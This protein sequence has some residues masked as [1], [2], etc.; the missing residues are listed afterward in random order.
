MVLVS[1]QEGFDVSQHWQE[2][3]GGFEL[4][5]IETIVTRD[6]QREKLASQGI[7]GDIYGGFVDP[8]FYIGLGIQVGIDSGI[9]AEG[10]VNMLSSIIQHRPVRLGETLMSAGR[11]ESVVDVPRGRRITTDVWFEDEKGRRAISV[12][13][14]SLKPDPRKDSRR[15]AGERPAPVIEDVSQLDMVSTH[16]MSPEGTKSYS[17]EGNAI[18]YEMEAANRAGFRA[19]I[20]GGGQGV[21]YLMAV[22]WG[23]GIASVDLE[24]YFR[25]PI[26][27]DDLIEV[28]IMPD[29]SALASVREGKVLTEVRVNT[30]KR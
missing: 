27:W 5:R 25:R 21:H 10:N 9:S 3:V 22:L 4:N 1:E 19:P 29:Q 13:R 26:F 30:I 24:L 14:Q 23:A 7:D 12:P 16:Q 8:S 18:H 15:G 6:T 2:P 11:I 20:I 28:G 17:S